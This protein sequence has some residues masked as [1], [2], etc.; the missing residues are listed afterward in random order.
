MHRHRVI[1][2]QGKLTP[3]QTAAALSR[4]ASIIGADSLWTHL[5]VAAGVPTVGVFGPS[6]ETR[7]GPW[8][9]R[10]RARTPHA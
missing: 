6:D 10:S 8:G 1:E 9:G 5:A 7:V 4:A 3:L 2:L